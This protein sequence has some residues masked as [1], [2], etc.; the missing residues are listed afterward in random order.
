MEEIAAA[1]GVS[2]V[3]VYGH[4]GDKITIFEAMA[5]AESAKIE[6][7]LLRPASRGKSLAETLHSFGLTLMAFLT[8]AEV[9]AFDR[10]LALEAPRHPD[11]ARRFFDAGPG[12]IRAQLAKTIAEGAARGEIMVDNP[13][14]AAEDLAALWQGFLPLEVRFG[15]CGPLTRAEVA[16]RVCRGVALFL[17]AHQGP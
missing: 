6:E 12:F 10:I 16:E 1:A 11:L 3:T 17:K 8:S 4:F 14:R 7:H 13:L 9:Q 5:R 2:K 15:V